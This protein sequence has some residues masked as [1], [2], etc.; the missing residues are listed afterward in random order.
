MSDLTL[1][2]PTK[3][4][5]YDKVLFSPIEGETPRPL[6]ELTSKEVSELGD[7]QAHIEVVYGSTKISLKKLAALKE[8]DLLALNELCDELVDIYVNGEHI[9]RG[10]VVAFEG[11]FG[12]KI[13]TLES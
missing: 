4:K 11:K 5:S 9:G 2:T 6:E 10:E 8:G 13:I 1:N 12:V 3:T 7:L